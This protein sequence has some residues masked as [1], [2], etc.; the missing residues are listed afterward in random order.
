MHLETKQSLLEFFR[1]KVEEVQ[2]KQNIPLMEVTQFYLVNLLA[3]ALE[4]QKLL[5]S[6]PE[7]N[8]DEPLALT[9]ARAVSAQNQN[10]R[11]QLLKNIGD[12]SLYVSG[13]FSDSLQRKVVDIDYYISMGEQAYNFMSSIIKDDH[14]T[15]L[16]PEV[17]TE[18]SKKFAR[19]VDLIAE[20]S[21]SSGITSDQDLLR[22]Y[23]RWL[24]T[25]SERLLYRLKEEGITPVKTDQEILH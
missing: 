9:Y 21:E 18:L 13:F 4:T 22:L 5:L 24:H 8:Q 7:E 19:L 17:F 3:E 20:I 15:K 23:E 16:F 11:F 6:G 14:R 2:Q 10:Q 25:K 12:R 1:Q